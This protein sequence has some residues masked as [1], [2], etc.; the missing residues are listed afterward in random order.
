MKKSYF[1]LSELVI[2]VSLF[3]LLVSLVLCSGCGP[4]EKNR[5][6][7]CSSNLK[8]IGIALAMHAGDNGGRFPAASGAEGLELLRKGNYLTDPGCYICPSSNAKSGA[9]A[10]TYG[11][12]TEPASTSYAYH[13]GLKQSDRPDLAMAA[14]LTGEPD[15]AANGG[16]PN[17]SDYGNILFVDGHVTGFTGASWF[18]AVTTGYLNLAAGSQEA[19]FPNR[20]R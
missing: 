11:S 13:G 3:A 10:L 6:S 5:R 9:G 2:V 19:V 18:N 16:K 4:S 8:Q 17:H 14:D 7:S 20:L 1:T 12:K 15:I